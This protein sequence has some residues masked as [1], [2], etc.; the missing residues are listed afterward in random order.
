[1]KPEL[2][3]LVIAFH[4]LELPALINCTHV[5]RNLLRYTQNQSLAGLLDVHP[6]HIL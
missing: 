1:M 6:L 4:E 5:L 3:F 2:S